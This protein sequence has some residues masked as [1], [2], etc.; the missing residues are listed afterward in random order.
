[1]LND[2]QVTNIL[3]ESDFYLGKSHTFKA[4]DWHDRYKMQHNYD[5][6]YVTY[7]RSPAR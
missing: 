3:R 4:R 6:Y 5:N 1:M 2:M 7:L